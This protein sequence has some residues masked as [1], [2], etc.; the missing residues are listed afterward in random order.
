MSEKTVPFDMQQ[1]KA[2][3]KQHPTPFYIYDEKAI[4][5]NA[6]SFIKAFNWAPAGFRNHFA[7]KACP[8]PF[9]LK[10][11]SEEGMGSDCS[12]LAELILSEA[13]GITGQKAIFTS[14][15]TALPEYVKAKE[16]GAVINLDDITQLPYLEQIGL[17][18][19]LS[20]RFNPGS[21]K[22]GNNI[23]GK[24]EEAKY[25]LT[26]EQ[27]FEAYSAAA[28]KGVKQ[29]GIH[30]MVASN[31]LNTDYFVETANLLLQ[32]L[33]E[34]SEKTGVSIDFI[35]FGG[36]I[37][38]PYHPD[39]QAVDIAAISSGIRKLYT[40]YITE[41]ALKPPAVSFECGRFVTGPHGYLVTEA[42]H[43]K[44]IYRDYIGVD[45]CMADMMRPGMYGAYHHIS[46][47]G[48]HHAE[49][50]EIYDVV[51]SLCENNDKFAI[52]RKLPHIE[53]GDLLVIHDTGAHGRAMGF[54]YNGKLR[55]AELLLKENGEVVEIRRRET[56]ADYFATL[57]FAGLPVS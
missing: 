15:N 5:D 9:I 52:R 34:I 21:A 11:L 37:G 22:K 26:R 18:D 55:T 41:A 46:V 30:T 31:E 7:V 36:G 40:K 10:I 27:M 49:A 51:G 42:I 14:N 13:V 38:I 35:N 44:H 29:F 25:G 12:S 28:A 53:R 6:Q 32:L 43:K 1:L 4:R 33:V 56:L 3:V 20:F 24:P 16:I 54:N 23:I 47:M 50:S 17:P 45:S 2:I 39:Q 48:K 57:D 19:T 8:N